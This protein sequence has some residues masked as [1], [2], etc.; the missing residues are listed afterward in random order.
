MK[1][2]RWVPLLTV[3]IILVTAGQVSATPRLTVA[4]LLHDNRRTASVADITLRHLDGAML[5]RGV[6][7]GQTL[8][9]EVRI[10]VPAREAVV[11]TNGRSTATLEAGSTATFAYTGAV[12]SVAISGGRT[13]FDDPLDFYHVAG[14][15]VNASPHGTAYSFEVTSH[16]VTITCTSGT[17]EARLVRSTSVNGSGGQ[18]GQETKQTAAYIER[19]DQIS[20][21]GRSTI[22]YALGQEPA[23]RLSSEVRADQVAAARGDADAEVNLGIRYYYGRGVSQDYA[24]ALH[25][26]Q[27]A[28]MQGNAYGQNDL[29]FMYYHGRGI[30]QDYAAALHY[31]QLAA[32]QKNAYGLNGLG[33]MYE[34]GRGV[35][36][37]YAS[38]LRY[39]QLAAA[40]GNAYGENNMGGMYDRGRGVSQN[41]T[42]ALHY[43]RLAAAQG[44]S[45][46]EVNLGVMYALG[47]GVSRDD[48]TAIH[49]FRLVAA[50]GDPFGEIELGTM[51][52]RGQGVPRD[53]AAAVHY[54]RLAAAQGDALG[55]VKLGTMY[56]IGTGVSQNHP[57]AARYYQLAAKQGDANAESMLGVMYEAG[58]GVS[59]SFATALHYSQLAAAQGD[60]AAQDTL[61]DMYAAGE[62]VPQN[63]VTAER[64]YRLAAAQGDS[65]AENS[66]GVL[67]EY[68]RSEQARTRHIL[69][70]DL[71]TA[72]KVESDLKAGKDFAAEA[73]QY[74]IDPGSKDKGGELGWIP[75]GSLA[76]EYEN[77]EFSAPIGQINSPVKSP[78]GWH[79]I[80]VEERR[81][82]FAHDYATASRYY[83][84]AA[85]QGNASAEYRLG[86]LYEH[87]DGVPQN[88][89]TALHYYKLA[90]AQGYADAA[91][92]VKRILKILKQRPPA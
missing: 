14:Q 20:A 42:I 38:A 85:A 67:Y 79:I 46:A 88:Y 18:S 92:E 13:S 86:T 39:Y 59:R 35:A 76:P 44:N 61:G 63:Y 60:A 30:S 62:G 50:Q 1:P 81:P 69:V 66:L 17:V 43:Y 54:F 73:K 11:I 15:G 80:E 26:Y 83:K 78:F 68:G 51:Y 65:D 12:E 8:P 91:A 33:I 74:S 49:R 7:T 23:G 34:L 40:Q 75:R 25:Y 90:A 24:T 52:F 21:K 36:Q 77:V 72:Q 55:E 56:T 82:G 3:L 84:L 64:Y 5:H 89:A 58:L 10:E 4:Q 19:V 57:T 87:G 31:Y 28:A 9:A 29:G 48:R 47:H 37:D 2:L 53:Y 70:A 16:R 32:A 71:A 6:K 41:Y 45:D 27:L 22:T